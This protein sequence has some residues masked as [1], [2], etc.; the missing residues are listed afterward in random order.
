MLGEAG[1]SVATLQ[2]ALA[3]VT[4]LE[5]PTPSTPDDTASDA[6]AASSPAPV[7]ALSAGVVTLET[8][9]QDG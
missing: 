9:I 3:Y 8:E 2:T 1:Y 7:P 5:V 4:H 6:S